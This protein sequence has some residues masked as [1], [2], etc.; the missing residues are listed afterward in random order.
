MLLSSLEKCLTIL[1]KEKI[2]TASHRPFQSNFEQI[3]FSSTNFFR[4]QFVSKIVLKCS[5]HIFT[6]RLASG[7]F[8]HLLKHEMIFSLKN[9][10]R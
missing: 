5:Y 6:S 3:F 4:H 1:L 9:E 10:G 2:L 8:S 7:K